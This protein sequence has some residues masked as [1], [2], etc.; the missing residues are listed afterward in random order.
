MFGFHKK[1]SNTYSQILADLLAKPGLKEDLLGVKE[2]NFPTPD[3][4][5]HDAANIRMFANRPEYQTWA[6]EVW[7]RVLSH[8]DHIL[9]SRTPADKLQFHVG[10]LKASLDLL[11]LSYQAHSTVEQ[12]EKEATPRR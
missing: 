8:L 2:V 9:D 6:K 1:P 5:R 3:Q 11:R 7:S 10:S 12:L 4:I